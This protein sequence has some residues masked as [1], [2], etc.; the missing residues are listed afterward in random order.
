MAKFEV[1]H[2]ESVFLP[3]YIDGN[4]IV[5]VMDGNSNENRRISFNGEVACQQFCKKHRCGYMQIFT[6]RYEYK[7]ERVK[8]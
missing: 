3:Y 4:K 5:Y 7:L 2:S 6:K 8:K 1:K